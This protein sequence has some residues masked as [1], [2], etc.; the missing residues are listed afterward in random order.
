LRPGVPVDLAVEIWPTC[1]VVP[2]GYQIGLTIRGHDYEH[3]PITLPDALYPMTGIGR[4]F[5]DDPTDRPSEVFHGRNTIH[6]AAGKSPYLLLPV[7]LND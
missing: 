4:F 5:H 7:I 2:P 6:F 1:I 3:A